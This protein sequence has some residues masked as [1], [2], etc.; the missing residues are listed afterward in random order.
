MVPEDRN[1]AVD[2]MALQ[3]LL[4]QYQDRALRIGMSTAA[5]EPARRRTGGYVWWQLDVRIYNI[6][7]ISIISS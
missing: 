1:G 5:G 4:Q 3:R 7:I 6:S 2:R